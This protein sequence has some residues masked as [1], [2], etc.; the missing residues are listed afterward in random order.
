MLFEFAWIAGCYSPFKVQII[1][2]RLARLIG[3]ARIRELELYEQ[4][5]WDFQHAKCHSSIKH[6]RQE[7]F[8]KLVLVKFLL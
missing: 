1:W 7:I 8:E 2:N 6:L 3:L 5:R 4:S